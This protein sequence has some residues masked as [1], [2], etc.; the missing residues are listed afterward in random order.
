MSS[1][2]SQPVA[3]D[4]G[5]GEP[6]AG[7]TGGGD[8]PDHGHLA[9]A[10]GARLGEQRP[11]LVIRQ[12]ATHPWSRVRLGGWFTRRKAEKSAETAPEAGGGAE[13]GTDRAG[14]REKAAPSQ[15]RG[16]GRGGSHH[17]RKKRR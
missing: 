10:P 11:V 4:P 3:A 16:K 14:R 6:D 9:P 12:H 2:R 15:Q 7:E 1:R 5:S 17:H 13:R 8:Q